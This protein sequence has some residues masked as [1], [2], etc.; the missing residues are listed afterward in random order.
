[1]STDAEVMAMSLVVI[2]VAAGERGLVQVPDERLLLQ[3]Q[4]LEAVGVQLHDRRIVDL[5]EQVAPIGSLQRQVDLLTVRGDLYIPSELF[6]YARLQGLL[7]DHFA[8]HQVRRL[9]RARERAQPADDLTG[10]GVRRHAVDLLYSGVD[11]HV[12]PEHLDVLVRHPRAA[13]RA[14]PRAW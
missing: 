12:L 2:D 10:I 9:R 11:R 4:L 5:L 6:R 14:C 1:M 13:G 3:R 8:V 7:R